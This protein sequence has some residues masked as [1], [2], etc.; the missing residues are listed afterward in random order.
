MLFR[1]H[2]NAQTEATRRQKGT[3]AHIQNLKT[4]DDMSARIR[5]MM[6]EKYQVEF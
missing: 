3:T 4:I 1:S 6:T 2:Y 5:R